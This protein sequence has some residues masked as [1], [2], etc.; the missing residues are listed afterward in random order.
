M[1]KNKIFTFQ[2]IINSW[3][4]LSKIKPVKIRDTG[5]FYHKKCEFK[6]PIKQLRYHHFLNISFSVISN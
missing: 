1:E 3:K 4:L 2:N 5:N 6:Y